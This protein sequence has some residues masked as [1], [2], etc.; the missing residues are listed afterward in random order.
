DVCQ[1]TDIFVKTKR[2][3]QLRVVQPQLGS[4]FINPFNEII[5]G[6]CLNLVKYFYQI[7][8]GCC[9]KFCKANHKNYYQVVPVL[10]CPVIFT[11]SC[12]IFFS[13]AEIVAS[14][15]LAC[16]NSNGISPLLSSF[17][18]SSGR[19][20]S[21]KKISPAGIIL[22]SVMMVTSFN[23]ARNPLSILSRRFSAKSIPAIPS[24]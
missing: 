2:T 10:F 3:D 22:L 7:G 20:V 21:L 12:S 5:I 14:S 19:I 24:R 16:T 15:S 9:Q 13:R 6:V 17:L 11:Y 1:F 8:V 23:N 4:S 18:F